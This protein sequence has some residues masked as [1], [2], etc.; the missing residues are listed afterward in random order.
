MT[1]LTISIS[2]AGHFVIHVPGDG[3]GYDLTFNTEEVGV[4]ALKRLLTKRQ[5]P[6]LLSGIGTAASPTQSMVDEWVKVN[7]VSRTNDPAINE[8][9]KGIDLSKYD[10]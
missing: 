4:A 6:E 2:P 1:P 8:L 7:G 10:L 9:T 3:D 5:S